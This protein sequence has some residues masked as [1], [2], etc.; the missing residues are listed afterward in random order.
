M[1]AWEVVVIQAYHP[2]CRAG[3]QQ[4][5]VDGIRRSDVGS[6]FSFPRYLCCFSTYTVR[7]RHRRAGKKLA[8]QAL[9][10]RNRRTGT[11]KP[12]WLT[13][14]PADDDSPPPPPAQQALNIF[15][16]GNTQGVTVLMAA[17][18]GRSV[19]TFGAALAALRGMMNKDNER[20]RAKLVDFFVP[21]IV[22]PSYL[23]CGVL[24][25]LALPAGVRS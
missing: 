8:E 6:V 21:L 9:L 14:A 16:S 24:L 4:N 22:P 13:Q 7:C 1:V 5:C 19:D 11:V 15:T 10:S 25:A 18:A 17:T 2:P 12:P 3:H 20:V 23:F